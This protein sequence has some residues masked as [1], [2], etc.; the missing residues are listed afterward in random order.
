V[1]TFPKFSFDHNLHEVPQSIEAFEAFVF[2]CRDRVQKVIQT[3]INCLD[4]KTE[5]FDLSKYPLSVEDKKSCLKILNYLGPALRILRRLNDAELV[6]KNVLGFFE[7]EEFVHS[8]DQGIDKKI[9]AII[10]LAHVYQWQAHFEKS[11]ELFYILESTY[12]GQ[13]NNQALI[14]TYWQHYAKNNFDQRTYRAALK[15]FE[16][17]LTARLDNNAPL[18]QMESSR[19]AI[20]R[21]QE[22]LTPK[23][24]LTGDRVMLVARTLE[25]APEL[26]SLIDKN[27][28]HLKNWMPWIGSTKS[29]SDLSSYIESAISWWQHATTYDFT[30]YHLATHKIIGS[31]GLH[32]IDWEKQSAAIGYWIDYDHEGHGFIVESVKLLECFAAQLGFHRIV[33]TCDKLNLRSANVPKRMGYRFESIQV[34]EC[35]SLGKHRDTLNYVKL[36]NSDFSDSVLLRQNDT[37]PSAND[38]PQASCGKLISENLPYGFFIKIISP[39]VGVTLHLLHHTKMVGALCAKS[40]ERSS[41]L[42][43]SDL[44]PSL[45]PDSNCQDS[46][47]ITDFWLEPKHQGRT[48]QFRLLSEL[49]TLSKKKQVQKINAIVENDQSHLICHFLKAG[50]VITEIVKSESLVVKTKSS[51]ETG[52]LKDFLDSGSK[53]FK[54][55]LTHFL[56]NS[57]S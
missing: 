18:E 39:G 15:Y 8:L 34:D 45:G 53:A 30:I 19:Q 52:A 57:K 25:Q 37:D 35:F 29:I 28:D 16:N 48:L 5:I 4:Y 49:L 47:L 31:A 33:I 51:L 27:R 21:T 23:D 9:A 10:R 20:A 7:T 11:N 40:E 6:L 38:L 46:F 32:S 41:S 12:L 43:R 26:F 36:L 3:K 13:I 55:Q 54:L 1:T 50:F 56:D 22:I 2:D 42:S 14:G 24:L 44:S 17:A